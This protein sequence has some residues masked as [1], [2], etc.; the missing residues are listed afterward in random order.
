V[1]G[2][3]GNEVCYPLPY[4]QDE[5]AVAWGGEICFQWAAARAPLAAIIF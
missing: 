3:E 1:D 5:V 4:T 2:S